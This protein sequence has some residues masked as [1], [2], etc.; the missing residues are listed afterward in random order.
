M[1]TV[2]HRAYSKGALCGG[3]ILTSLYLAISGVALAQDDDG[4]MPGDT[5]V[6]TGSRIQRDSTLE[7]AGPVVTIGAEDIKTAGVID[8][9]ALLRE[10]P[11]LQASLPGSFSAFNGGALGA[12]QLNLRNL[13]TVRTLVLENGR[14]HVAGIEGTGTVD[15]NT[16][17]TALLERVD[18]S[19]GGASS[20]Y[21]ADA[22]TGVVNFLMRDGDSFDGLEIRTQG[23]ISS[24]GDAEEF[25]IS[26]ANGFEVDDGRGSIVFG[27]EFQ[28]QTSIFAGEREFAGSG[29]ESRVANT[30]A[31]QSAFNV[32]P[33]FDNA[34]IPDRRLPI[35]SDGGVIALGDGNTAGFSSAFVEVVGSGGN[36]GCDTIGAAAIP[37]CQIFDN[38]TLRPYNPGDVFSD[39]FAAS[40][41]DGVP[42]EPDD[43]LLLPEVDRFLFQSAMTYELVENV[44]FF[45][46]V[47]YVS[48]RT[49][50]S[51][52]VNGF[53][54]D[55][56]IA[57]DNPFIPAALQAQIA[58]LQAEG[59]DP[60][61]AV[62]R[63][64]L[65]ATGRSNPVAERRTLRIVGGLNGEIPDTGIHYELSFNYGRTDA[66]ITSRTRVE[67]RYFAAID[68]VI[69]PVSGEIV[70]RSSID[71]GANPPPSSS[72]PAQNS[73]FAITT[74]E[75]GD[76]QCRPVN[77]FGKNS[78]SQEAAD[79]I[80]VPVTSQNE[81][82]QRNFLA[83]V[84]GDSAE[85]FELPAGPV[86]FALGYEFRNERSRN[87]PDSLTRAGLTFGTIESRGGPS[88]PSS[89]E[90]EVNEYFFEGSIPVLK[91]LP[92]VSEFE[93]N[94]AVRHSNY[95]VY[96][97][98]TTWTVGS[99][100][101]PIESL[102]FRGTYSRAVRV[103]NI[104]E[105]FAP[106]FTVDI[107]A[108]EDP[109][110]PQFI[111]AG[112]Q[113]RRANCMKLVG[114]SAGAAVNPYNSTNFVSAFIPGISGGNPDLNPETADTFTVGAVYHPQG[115]FGGALDGLTIIVDFYDIE[116][117]GMI[118][119]LDGFDI[120][121]NC[122][123]APDLN[124]QFCD[125]IDRDPTNGFITGF[126]S[127]Q[128]NLASVETQ[129]IDWR[130]DYVFEIPFDQNLGSLRLS[131][132]GTKFLKNKETRDVS[133]PT[134]ITD[135]LGTL[136]R[137]EWIV[138]FNADWELDENWSFGW[139]GRFESSQLTTDLEPQDLESNPNF[140]NI[141]NT[142]ATIINDFS[143]SY[144][145]NDDL[146]FYGGVNDVFDVDP[147]I[148][149][150]SRPAGP[151]GRF[152]FLGANLKL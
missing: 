115:D 28:K 34:F 90:Y 6:V 44:N 57:L 20:I 126:R 98:T 56:P 74:F 21:G 86:G 101:A 49:T 41:G 79:F 19:T 130:V 84:S 45:A 78:I 138:N 48:T 131:S 119:T 32:D 68:A 75:P 106:Q 89:G 152:F 95:D 144:H 99:R 53:N 66:D 60:I 142:S 114:A 26:A 18:I 110:N 42:S 118:D 136:T 129:G 93:V 5:I 15:V 2:S 47:K 14:R 94:G 31:V 96:E 11:S 27:A 29:L 64:V 65:D 100:Y 69:D 59:I 104:E 51:N 62:S 87:D 63:D 16:I 40:G 39:P 30:P 24:K 72:F 139:H 7:A 52:Q 50:E 38:G 117:D 148:G 97:D 151:R 141:P 54:D 103:P 116:I 33:I 13:G 107:G 76:G 85:F 58:T 8:I 127:G 125:A 140:V 10:S 9:G 150:L 143:V 113:F 4:A 3:T 61:I 82:E 124:N 128:I 111:D 71:P 23:G 122:V 55:I 17:S 91:D 137:P 132:L 36:I 134:A 83:T 147:Y 12:S 123:D 22:V 102:T 37:T 88:F 135:V 70:C 146:E 81:I 145:L 109:C 77:I 149:N 92:F 46:D 105:A 121:Q 120:A 25:F 1:R 35:S 73:N 43:E 67:D 108:S 80:F 133:D 112:S